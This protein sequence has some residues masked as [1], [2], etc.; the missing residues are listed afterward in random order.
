MKLP[1]LE[2]LNRIRCKNSTNDTEWQVIVRYFTTGVYETSNDL[3]I[4]YKNMLDNQEC[5]IKTCQILSIH[6]IMNLKMF[7]Y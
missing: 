7:K 4:C 2:Q 5:M 3:A 1:S 6:L